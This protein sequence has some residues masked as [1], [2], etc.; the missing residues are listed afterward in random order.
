MPKERSETPRMFS[1][2]WVTPRPHVRMWWKTTPFPLPSNQAFTPQLLSQSKVHGSAKRWC[3]GILQLGPRL[4]PPGRTRASPQ[5]G[6]SAPGN[7]EQGRQGCRRSRW[8]PQRAEGRLGGEAM[9]LGPA[10][11][12]EGLTHSPAEWMWETNPQERGAGKDRAKC[13][14]HAGW[15]RHWGKAGCLS[16]PEPGPWVC[17]P[18]GHPVS[19]ATH[20]Q[21]SSPAPSPRLRDG[22]ALCTRC[23]C[24]A[25]P[26]AMAYGT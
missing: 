8:G 19:L 2:A 7:A 4:Y 21:P 22:A 13:E 10:A 26:I 20:P 14:Q 16:P 3:T 15:M 24:Q 5:P 11:V 25:R 17:L 6:S 23:R 9:P 1:Q 18:G 12:W